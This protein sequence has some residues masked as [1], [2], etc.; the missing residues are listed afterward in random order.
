L[1]RNIAEKRDV[2]YYSLAHSTLLLLL[3]YLVK[4]RNRTLA[5]SYWVAHA[6]AHKITETT[7]SLIICYLFNTNCIHFRIVC[8]RSQMY[9][10]F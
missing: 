5:V 8:A 1:A 2:N 9:R 3:H 6:S 4:C 7:K 10:L